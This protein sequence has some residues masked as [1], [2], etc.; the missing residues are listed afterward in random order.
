MSATL[1]VL[2]IWSAWRTYQSL[3]DQQEVYLRGRVAAMA[4]RLEQIPGTLPH[5][6]WRVE[7]AGE[8][9][10]SLL[11]LTIFEEPTPALAGLWQGEELFREERIRSGSGVDVFRAFI[12]FH[13]DSRLQVARI[14]LDAHSADFLI[15]PARGHLV[16]VAFGGILI[17]VLTVISARHS[18]IAA[19]A[20]QRQIE[21]EHLARIGEMSA[22]LAHEIRNPLGTIKGFAQL[23]AER[24]S[25][26]TASLVHPILQQS[27]RLENLVKDLLL[28]GRPAAAPT[29]QAI[30]SADVVRLVGQH[31]AKMAGQV[32]FRAT[33]TS[34]FVLE[35]DLSMVEQVLLNLLRNAVESAG[36]N[37]GAGIRT[38]PPF[39]SFEAGIRGTM[40]VLRMTDSGPGFGEEA[41]ARIYEPFFTSKASGTGLGLCISRKLVAALGGSLSVGNSAGGGGFAEVTLPLRRE[42]Q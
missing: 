25:N 30:D 33:G 41:L 24:E 35:T 1:S 21:L 34:P 5:D 9:D 15:T 12:P 19:R 7:L 40:A 28:Y 37:P 22:V 26:P 23:L 3:V 14:D 20:L 13:H 11:G 36:S 4:S 17:V 42:I 32:E 38:N 8:A 16:L 18:R 31:A 2:L 39:V 27:E 29:W 10:D 6:Q